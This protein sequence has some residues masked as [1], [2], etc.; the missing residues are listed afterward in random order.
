MLMN[1]GGLIT[2]KRAR[3][4]RDGEDG[5]VVIMTKERRRRVGVELAGGERTMLTR[6]NA[7][8]VQFDVQRDMAFD[9]NMK[10]IV[11]HV[12][13][14]MAAFFR[15]QLLAGDRPDGGKLPRV[16]K[17]TQHY[18]PRLG[19][20]I[21]TRSGYMADHWWLGKIRG[22][23]F[24]SFRLVKPWGGDGGPKPEG[25]LP[26]TNRS[27]TIKA[28]LRRPKPVDFQSIRGKSAHRMAELFNEAIKMGFPEVRTKPNANENE[29][30]LPEL[31]AGIEGLEAR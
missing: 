26:Q 13:I 30:T 24:R 10:K 19:D 16:A 15:K 28:L 14:G 18:D 31:V 2:Q 11:E 1:V 12:T 25:A 23:S 9:L 6:K 4:V 21:G 22:N 3:R 17:R 5:V 29:G 8:R 7:F 20:Q 27:N